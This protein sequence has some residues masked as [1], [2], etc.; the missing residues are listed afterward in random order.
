MADHQMLPLKEAGSDRGM[1]QLTREGF[2]PALLDLVGDWL[3]D[4]RQ[5]PVIACG[6]VGSRQGWT[7]APYEA[8]PSKPLAATMVQAPTKD[9]RL[10]VWVIPGLKQVSPPDVMRGEET[11]IAGFQAESPDFDGVICLPG[12]HS[13][14]VHVSAGEVVSFRTFMTGEL[15]ACLT[16]ATVLRHSV[17]AM[18]WDEAGFAE[19]LDVTLSRPERLASELFS[20]R[21][22]DLLQDASATV[23]RARLSGLLIGAELAAAK[24]YWLGQPVAVIGSEASAAPYLAALAAQGVAPIRADGSE[25]SR[26]GLRAAYETVKDTVQ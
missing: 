15:F 16:D 6:M 14:W 20:L 5:T 13:K 10:R 9:P 19:G 18:G 4:H 3:S 8:V 7:E 11:Q 26:R 25:M 17:A 2:E 24:P 12:T 23:A 1:G 22:A 21:A